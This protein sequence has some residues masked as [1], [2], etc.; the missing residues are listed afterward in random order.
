MITDADILFDLEYKGIDSFLS[1][2]R[3]GL[4]VPSVFA[5]RVKRI[6]DAAYGSNL[7]KRSVSE[8]RRSGHFCLMPYENETITV[9][10]DA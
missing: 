1:E 8:K 10:I 7:T 5:D 2:L 9:L 4:S 6:V 3:D